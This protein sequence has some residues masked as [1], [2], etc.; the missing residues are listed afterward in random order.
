MPA[1]ALQNPGAPAEEGGDELR[2]VREA[3]LALQ[4]EVKMLRQRDE[5][6]AVPEALLALQEE[7]K[8]LRHAVSAGGGSNIGGGG[9]GSAE[10]PAPTPALSHST[11]QIVPMRASKPVDRFLSAALK[12]SFPMWVLP[13]RTLLSPSFQMFRP[14]E[15][16]RDAG[17]LVEWQPGMSPVLFC[18]HTWL[19]HR[20][21]DSAQ[22]DKFKTLT[23]VLRRILAGE[24]DISTNWIISLIY[25]KAAKRFR[26]KAASSRSTTARGRQVSRPSSTRSSRAEGT[27]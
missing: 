26:C 3:L 8:M 13:I 1:R 7:V 17:A 6:R 5:L 11:S 20:H 21:P 22:G 2:A 23:G 16:L 12:R 24:L 19:R 15:E 18:S 9:G 27:S 14:H 4:E 10:L 25:G